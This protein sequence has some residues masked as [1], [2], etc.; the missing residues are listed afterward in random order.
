MNLR[1]AGPMTACTTGTIDSRCV[2]IDTVLVKVA[3]RCNINCTYCYVYNMGD[4]GWRDMPALMSLATV[5]ALSKALGQLA[6]DQARPFAT[7]L[8]GGEPLMLGARR[9]NF[10]LGALRRGLPDT[11]PLCMQ[12][13][14]MLLTREIADVCAEHKVSISISLDGPKDVNDRFRLGKTGESTHAKVEAGIAVLRSHPAAQLLYSGLLCVVDPYSDPRTVYEYFKRLGAPSMD[15]LYR[16]GNHSA[17]PY[18][19]E[20]FE[21][22]E[23][24][25]WFGRLLDVYL[26]DSTPPRVR[27]LDDLVKLSLGGKGIKEGLGD[28]DYGIAIIETD[29]SI[30][31]NDTLKSSFDGA[32]RFAQEWSVHTHLLSDVFG[33]EEFE[34]YHELQRPSSST[35]RSCRFLRVCGGGMPLH[36]W[37]K[38][39]GFDNPSVYCSDQK[40]LVGKVVLR[41]KSEGL[42][43]DPRLL[44]PGTATESIP[45]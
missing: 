16:D 3:S 29:G 20:S 30:S 19:K 38:E 23:Y 15:F 12:T 32:D 13:N 11:Y 4:G 39:T 45:A 25:H 17:M 33:T 36:R 24:G 8:H 18:G 2:E 28:T 44:E 26:E 14:G 21:S 5:D 42:P 22:T 34:Q 41:L 6:N 43:V 31:K 40:A 27:F 35:C 7:V 37:R 9:L 10:L 1:R